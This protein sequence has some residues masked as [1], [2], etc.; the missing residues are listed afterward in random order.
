[1]QWFFFESRE[2]ASILE[3]DLTEKNI[4]EYLDQYPI[5]EQF[6]FSVTLATVSASCTTC[7]TP[8]LFPVAMQP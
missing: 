4:Q 8:M 7:I 2:A 1:M 3:L 5:S 6:R